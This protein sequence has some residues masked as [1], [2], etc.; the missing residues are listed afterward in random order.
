M[1][2][3]II[4]KLNFRLIMMISVLMGILISS[5]WIYQ[6]DLLDAQMIN[7]QD[8]KELSG[9]VIISKDQITLTT[10]KAILYAGS[11]QLELFGNIIMINN[12]DTLKCD[13]LFYFPDKNNLD[14]F[15]AAGHV[16]LLNK[17]QNIY[18]Y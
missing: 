12:N 15:I 14:Y 6:A 4:F 11:N 17:D 9:N 1:N 16:I 3:L 18:S 7:N 2:K 8:I 5:E 10:K 13:T